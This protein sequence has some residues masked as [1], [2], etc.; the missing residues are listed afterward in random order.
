[1]HEDDVKKRHFEA[2]RRERVE[3]EEELIG[4]RLRQRFSQERVLLVF[5]LCIL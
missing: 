2:G 4:V 3:D 5:L 1:M